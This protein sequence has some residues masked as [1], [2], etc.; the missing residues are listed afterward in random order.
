MLN[1]PY[2]LRPVIA[3]AAALAVM[4]AA[5]PSLRAQESPPPA[6]AEDLPLTSDERG[7]FV[8][9]YTVTTADPEAPPISLRIFEEDGALMGA[10]GGNS[11]TR[12]LYQGGSVFRP[13]DAPT[14]VVTFRTE[15]SQATQVSIRSPEGTMQGVRVKEG[16]GQSGAAPDLSASGSLYDELARMD[17]VLFAAVYV[18]CDAD[19]AWALLSED[20]EFYHDQSGAESGQEVK[21]SFERFTEWCPREH[22]MTRELVE[23]SLRVYPIHD[24]GAVQMGVHRFVENGSPSGTLA[25]FVH[26]WQKE[27]GAW[28]IS[29]A[30]S[31]DHHSE[32]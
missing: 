26:L 3:L 31:F 27:G 15:G 29:R 10:I 24:Y 2:R 22:G 21:E 25:R 32:R 20:V 23:G 16:E 11:A 7:V 19:Q 5:A 17:S 1:A 9:L 6:T 13:E 8:G 4:G 28:R 12:M 14:F 30:L 18:L